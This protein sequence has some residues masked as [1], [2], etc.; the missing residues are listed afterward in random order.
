MTDERTF[1]E[2]LEDALGSIDI[3]LDRADVGPQQRQVIDRALRDL[4]STS[5]LVLKDLRESTELRRLRALEPMAERAI[6]ERDKAVEKLEAAEKARKAAERIA[7]K[8][9][10]AR[11]GTEGRTQ[12]TP[13][14]HRGADRAAFEARETPR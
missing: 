4:K 8:E 12:R 11:I 14:A 3:A 7:E 1:P 6:R 2:F 9:R 10:I 5:G 13:C